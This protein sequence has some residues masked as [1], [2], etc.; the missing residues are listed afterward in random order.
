M[1]LN[2][3][4]L[5]HTSEAV[6]VVS[7]VLV[8]VSRLVGE[9]VYGVYPSLASSTVGPG[10]VDGVADAAVLQPAWTALVKALSPSGIE[11]PCGG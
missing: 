6:C 1:T 8:R 11:L 10:V 7:G 4:K 9:G 2:R 5:I 3:S